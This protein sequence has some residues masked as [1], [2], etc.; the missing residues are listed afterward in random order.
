MWLYIAAPITVSL[1]I[2]VIL[3]IYLMRRRNQKSSTKSFGK[4]N[5][6]QI[7]EKMTIE[8]QIDLLP[9][10]KGYEVSQRKIKLGKQLGS[11]T[12]AAVAGIGENEEKT[13][14]A[15]KIINRMNDKEVS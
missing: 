15:V 12:F 2:V 6:D 7:N 4:G 8:Q 10:D 3:L 5:P 11:G 9:Y 1:V 14:V 13:T